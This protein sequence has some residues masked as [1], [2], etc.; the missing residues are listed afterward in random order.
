MRGGGEGGRKCAFGGANFSK[1]GKAHNLCDAAKGAGCRLLVGSRPTPL[2]GP[3]LGEPRADPLAFRLPL[4][5]AAAVAR[6]GVVAI[7]AAALARPR[8]GAATPPHAVA[9]WRKPRHRRRTRCNEALSLCGRILPTRGQRR[10]T[11]CTCPI[12]HSARTGSRVAGRRWGAVGRHTALPDGDD[13][14]VPAGAFREAC[15][16][17]HGRCA[18]PRLREHL[19]Y[20]GAARA[21]ESR[22]CVREGRV[23]GS[24]TASADDEGVPVRTDGHADAACRGAHEEG[25]Q[26]PL[27][28]H[29]APA[30]GGMGGAANRR[31]AR[32]WRGAW[33]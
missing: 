16:D 23:G 33:L 22:R 15:H 32:S 19:S 18:Q 21:R 4:I 27:K 20:R 1:D 7:A 10:V 26:T 6:G 12:H 3:A 29:L 24:R 11:H 2:R 9:R 30:Q 5:A 8:R 14:P 13:P 28:P 25:A 17:A 31:S